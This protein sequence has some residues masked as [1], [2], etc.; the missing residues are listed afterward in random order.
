M[1]LE[2]LVINPRNPVSGSGDREER[3][4]TTTI[5][6]ETRYTAEDGKRICKGEGERSCP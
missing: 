4:A 3:T 5:L 1:K 2:G 6:N